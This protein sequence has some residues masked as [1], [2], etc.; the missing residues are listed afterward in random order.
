[1]K[2]D[3]NNIQNWMKEIGYNNNAIYFGADGT[4][5]RVADIIQH[6]LRWFKAA[7]QSIPEKI[8]EEILKE[9]LKNIHFIRSDETYALVIQAMELYAS[10]FKGRD[11]LI[12]ILTL[13]PSPYTVFVSEISEKILLKTLS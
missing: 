9:K 5:L 1:M 10:Q 6:Y 12:Q 8:A 2:S 3:I 4:I 7:S 13:V 11:N